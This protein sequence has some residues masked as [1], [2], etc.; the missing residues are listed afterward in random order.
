MTR[1]TG[2]RFW[3]A[4]TANMSGMIHHLRRGHGY[5]L[6]LAVPH[7]LAWNSTANSATKKKSLRP[8]ALA[9]P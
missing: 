6:K 7:D 2:A 5:K 8:E 4:T 9:R 3:I 1:A